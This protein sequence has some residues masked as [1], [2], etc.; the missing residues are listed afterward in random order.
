[1][2]R[3]SGQTLYHPSMRAVRCRDGGIAVLDVPPPE[4]DGVCVEVASAGICGSDL[5]LLGSDFL[6]DVTLGHEIAGT[7]PD[8]TPVAIEPVTVCG[9][10]DACIAGDTNLCVEALTIFHGVAR[11]GGM[12]DEILV[13]EAALV[14]LPAGLE[15]RNA[16]LAE[17][18]GVVVHG[19]RIVRFPRETGRRVGIIGAGPIGLCAVPAVAAAGVEPVLFARHEAQK[20]AGARLGAKIGDTEDGFDLVIECAGTESALEDAI[21]RCRP[22]GTVLMLGIY[23]DG[24]SVPGIMLGMKEVR[25]VPSYLYGR[26]GAV[27]DMETATALLASRPD[28]PDVLITHRFPLDAAKE[29]FAVAADRA[30]GAIKVVLEP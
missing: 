17:P 25:L 8:G 2:L 5:H 3:A 23:W 28:L 7:A 27:R 12:A 9:V 6:Q 20:L 22:G 16:S 26:E 14:R 1:M 15:P 30:A 29:A 18:L 24:M 4:G 11:D 10:C 13:P 21:A 19:L